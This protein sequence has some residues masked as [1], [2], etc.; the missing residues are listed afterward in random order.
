[1]LSKYPSTRDFFFFFVSS[2]FYWR[3]VPL[4][5]FDL[6]SF[7]FSPRRVFFVDVPGMET[8]QRWAK[9]LFTLHRRHAVTRWT[10][11]GEWLRM[12]FSVMANCIFLIVRRSDIEPGDYTA[13]FKFKQVEVLCNDRNWKTGKGKVLELFLRWWNYYCGVSSRYTKE[14]QNVFRLLRTRGWNWKSRCSRV[15]NLATGHVDPDMDRYWITVS[16]REIKHL[17]AKYLSHF[18]KP[19][20]HC[21]QDKYWDI[22][23]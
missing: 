15:D 14:V 20:C 8:C 23:I 6:F 3:V 4:C 19:I 10:S 22:Y 21:E 17:A 1:M 7:S 11:V 18:K 2:S 5:R 16:R 12:K 9:R 13:W